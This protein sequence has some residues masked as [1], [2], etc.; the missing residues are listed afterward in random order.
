MAAVLQHVIG[1]QLRPHQASRLDPV[2]NPALGDV[3]GEVPIDDVQAVDAAVQAAEAAFREWSATPILE[4]ARVM[5]RYRELLEAHRRELAE[6]V[7]REHG[8]ILSDAYNE[9]GRGIEVVELAAG[10]PSLLKGEVLPEVAHGV[11][12]TMLRVPLGVVAGITPFN[13]PA[14][15]PLWMIP[16]AIV[17]GNTFVLKP[18]ERTPLT[19]MRLLELLKEAGL[20]DGVVNLVHGGAPVVDALLTHPRIRAIS[21]VGSQPVAD[22]VYRTASQHH[23]R[24]QALGGAKNFHIV[25]PD[26]NLD[27]AVDALMGSAYGSAGE[28]CLAGS[29]VVA[30]GDVADALVQRLQD[31][32]SRLKVGNGLEAGIEM[33]PLIRAQHRERVQGYIERGVAE[34]ATLALDGRQH[35]MPSEGFFLGP[36]LFDRVEAH[37]TI[38]QEEIFGPVLSV[39]RRPS[40][41]EAVTTANGSRF[42]N[43]ATIYTTSGKAAR[44]FRDH[45]QAGMLGVNIGVPA[46]VAWFPF[47]GWK[48]SFYGDLHATG[49]DAFWFYTERRVITA[50]W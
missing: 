17:S 26:A 18:S 5:F 7:T 44:Y 42:G 27:L 9:V 11:D 36:T 20:P 43:T 30:V 10:A 2:F 32:A 46:P 39:I 49:M 40:L 3:I 23:K 25:M 50:R 24:V 47:A 29:V 22:Y 41:E 21:F 37:M 6:S 14:M 4:R 28:R 8:K 34:G 12:V 1:G 33:G 45:V 19:S 13:F 15:I 31:K 16:P 48:D 35:D 38:A